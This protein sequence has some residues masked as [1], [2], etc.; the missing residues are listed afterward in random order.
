MYLLSRKKKKNKKQKNKKRKKKNGFSKANHAEW[1]KEKTTL[2]E[3]G[4]EVLR[5]GTEDDEN[6]NRDKGVCTT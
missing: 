3:V 1:L 4:D 6:E 5:V 2:L